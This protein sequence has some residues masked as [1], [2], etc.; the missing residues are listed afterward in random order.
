MFV[1]QS[2]TVTKHAVDEIGRLVAAQVAASN[3]AAV[4]AVQTAVAAA[5]AG[6][7][8]PGSSL[9][10]VTPMPVANAGTEG[11]AASSARADHVHQLNMTGSGA[12]TVAYDPP[13]GVWTVAAQIASQL[14][15][16]T[17]FGAPTSGTYTAKTEWLDAAQSAFVCTAGGSPGTWSQTTCGTAAMGGGGSGDALLAANWQGGVIA[18]Y[19]QLF[20]AGSEQL[21][22]WAPSPYGFWRGQGVTTQALGAAVNTTA[23]NVYAAN[24]TWVAGLALSAYGNWFVARCDAL[25]SVAGTC[26]ASNYW[27]LTWETLAGTVATVN[28]ISGSQSMAWVNP[29]PAPLTEGTDIALYLSVSK[30]GS[31]GALTIWVQSVTM[32][33]IHT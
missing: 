16:D 9:G 12:V 23:G 31:P 17:K 20:E 22:T 8:T 26:D 33:N 6:L 14:T 32:Y 25:C 11:T 5:T 15:P 29:T 7:T 2:P 28:V 3:T 18:P 1:P 27:T 10:G 30:T 19:Y 24:T 4:A 13:S 21:Y